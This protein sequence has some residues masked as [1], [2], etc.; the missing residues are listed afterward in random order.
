MV[1][2]GLAAALTLRRDEETPLLLVPL[3]LA[4]LVLAGRL[5]AA[6]DRPASALI[7]VGAW[8]A[9]YLVRVVRA[10]VS[11]DR[12]RGPLAAAVATAAAV[13]AVVL[14]G[15]LLHPLP[16]S[17]AAVAAAVV[18]GLATVALRGRRPWV[19]A[20]VAAGTLLVVL[21]VAPRDPSPSPAFL[22][23]TALWALVVW[24]ASGRLLLQ[25]G[26]AAA[27]PVLGAVG[28]PLGLVAVAV[29]HTRGVQG[30]W[31]SGCAAGGAVAVLV[32]AGLVWRRRGV[33]AWVLSSLVGTGVAFA[34]LACAA[35]LEGVSVTVVWAVLAAV[36]AH[37]GA[38]EESPQWTAWTVVLLAVLVVRVLAVD[39]GQP[40]VQRQLFLA[41]AGLE[42]AYHQAALFNSRA[43]A[44]LAAAGA[45][46]LAAR[47][48]LRR[49]VAA[50]GGTLAVC[51]YAL[52]LV[53]AVT[54]AAALASTYPEVP[55]TPMS[56]EELTGYVDRVELAAAEQS[57]RRAASATV[58][59]GG[60]GAL[61]LAAGFSFRSVLHRW[62]GLVVL[63]G[64]VGKLA[65][66]DIWQLPRLLQVVVLGAVGVLLLGAGFLYARFGNRLLELLR[67][68]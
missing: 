12:P 3:A 54:E 18:A 34:G 28:G 31:P 20:V 51:G 10:A 21:A 55:P 26:A 22:G 11:V 48:L 13:L 36:V 65:L 58:A 27:V 57:N 42:G 59:M 8:L 17:V 6:E 68:D 7:W 61:L 46:L 29:V 53:L 62:V 47:A 5:G 19:L 43:L 24:A 16:T 41:T 49:G 63:A 39:L 60:F 37:V 30:P 14:A 2:G 32:L 45:L 33:A 67:E 9:V 23:V 50:V 56:A 64:T 15:V 4:F 25:Q 38:R 66:W 44:E 40:E 35:A 1:G 52:L